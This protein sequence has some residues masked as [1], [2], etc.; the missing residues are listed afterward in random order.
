[1]KTIEEKAIAAY[2]ENLK[3]KKKIRIEDEAWMDWYKM[4]YKQAEK[5]C[6]SMW[7]SIDDRLNK[8]PNDKDVLIRLKDGSVRRYEEEWEEEF[9][10]FGIV[11]HW[12][13]IPDIKK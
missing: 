3:R 2:E 9:G 11:T 5:D 13:A 7:I 12:M 1:M 8:M 4:G 10:L 6:G